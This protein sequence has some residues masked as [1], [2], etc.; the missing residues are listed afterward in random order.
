[1]TQFWESNAFSGM[2]I[3]NSPFHSQ[4]QCPCGYAAVV[5]ASVFKGLLLPYPDSN[6]SA[7]VFGCRKPL[8][9]SP[10]FHST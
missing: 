4:Q 2:N 6:T 3:R 1:M 9:L 10:S 7:G 8:C 5:L